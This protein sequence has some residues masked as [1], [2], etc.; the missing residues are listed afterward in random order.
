MIAQNVGMPIIFQ[1]M[2]MIKDEAISVD[3][4]SNRDIDLDAVAHSYTCKSYEQLRLLVSD[5]YTFLVLNQTFSNQ[6]DL[7]DRLIVI[8]ICL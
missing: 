2:Q 7:F 5:V 4:A 6:F 8:I 1:M 3:L